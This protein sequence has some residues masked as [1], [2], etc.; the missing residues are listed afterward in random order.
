MTNADWCNSHLDNVMRTLW[1][2]IITALFLTY[3]P[4]LLLCITQH[5]CR[6]FDKI[7]N[8]QPR[9]SRTLLYIDGVI[10]RL[11]SVS[12]ETTASL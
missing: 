10:N 6:H 12:V 5:I 4:T 11:I 9:S 2:N 3:L 8:L 1:Y 7:N